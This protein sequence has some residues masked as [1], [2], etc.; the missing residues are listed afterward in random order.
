[1][2]LCNNVLCI[3]STVQLKLFSYVSQRNPEG[4]EYA[5]NNIIVVKIILIY[6]LITMCDRVRGGGAG[7]RERE[8]ERERE[9]LE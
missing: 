7:E 2:Y 6:T 4:M 8:R 9:Y 5:N 1:M 3:F